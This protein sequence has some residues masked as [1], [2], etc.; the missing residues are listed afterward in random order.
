MVFVMRKLDRVPQTLGDKLRALR[1][2][3]AVTLEMM[4]RETHVQRRYLEALER[5][6]YEALPEPM[7][8][9]NFIRAY[10]RVLSADADYFIELYEE[11]CGRCDLVLPS[12]M[13]R[14]RVRGKLLFAWNTFVKAGAMACI[15]LGILGY[16][17]WQIWHM[18]AP[19]T[20]VLESPDDATMAQEAIVH[21][22]GSVEG[23]ATVAIDGVLVVVNADQTFDA[24]VDLREGLNV[25]T[26][27]AQRRYSREA[28]VERRVVF[29]P[30]EQA[31]VSLRP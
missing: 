1:K 15:A 20:I 26:V 3:Q 14:Q 11:E 9:R 19:P 10:A 22:R 24:V 31:V 12:V 5:G 18:T 28:Q 30:Q 25:I 4:E 7:Y 17:G 23:E 21:V 27:T 29:D 13:P 6:R 8:T 16:L 2:G